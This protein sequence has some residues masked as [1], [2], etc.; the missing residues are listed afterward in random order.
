M[1][2]HVNNVRYIEW[3]IDS[4]PLDFIRNRT[5]KELEINYLAEALYDNEIYIGRE[6]KEGSL[7]LH[8]LMR[9]AD[10]VEICRART[11]WEKGLPV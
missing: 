10:N 7:F 3:I 5:L 2:E 1:N 8:S 9:P 11:V 6:D 4:F